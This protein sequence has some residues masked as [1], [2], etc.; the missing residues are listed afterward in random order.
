MELQQQIPWKTSITNA[1]DEKIEIRG[2]D[3]VDMLGKISF[4]DQIYLIITGELPDSKISPVFEA[5]LC[6]AIDHGAGTP[7]A[8]AARTAISGGASINGAAAAGLL[9]LGDHHGAAVGACMRMLQTMVD[10]HND[11]VSLDAKIE[12]V[13]TSFEQDCRHIPGLGHR[14]HQVDPRTHRLAEIA[15]AYGFDG[16]FLACINRMSAILSQK[17]NKPIPVNIDG[18]LAAILC[19]IGFPTDF[20]NVVFMISRMVGI[21]TQAMEEKQTQKPMRHIDPLAIEYVGHQ[22]RKIEPKGK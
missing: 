3:L 22:P 1:L 14:L 10:P 11:S 18:I 13:L 20:G 17:K 7:S 5:I 9:T 21:F 2:Y 12:A 15:D 16:R 8:L 4:S 19:E 6:A